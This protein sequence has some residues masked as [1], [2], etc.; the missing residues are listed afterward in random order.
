MSIKLSL[1]HQGEVAKENTDK[2]QTYLA[3]RKSVV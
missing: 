1:I 2:E 3:D